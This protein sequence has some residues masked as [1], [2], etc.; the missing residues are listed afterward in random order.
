VFNARHRLR[1][2]KVTHEAPGVVSLYVT[3]RDLD[4]V[5]AEAGQFFLW[6][7]LT[8]ELWWQAH[9][10]S[11]SAAPNSRWLRVTIKDLGD[12][13]AAAGHLRPGTRIFAEGPY[14]TFTTARRTHRKVALIAGGI[15]ITPLRA[16]L[17]S[18]EAAPGEIALLYRVE[19]KHDLVFRDEIADLAADRGVTLHALVGTEIGNDH[20]DQLGVPALRRLLPDI[21]ERDVFLCG[22][23]GLVDAV[24]RRL[25]RLGVPRAQIHDERFAY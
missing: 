16:L 17:E 23:P 3:G 10:F 5:G 24:H 19:R 2:A 15:G 25:R 13:T 22:P 6:R 7:F 1:V 11:L 20:T 14:G 18:M 4:R 9:P 21:A 12:F 8:K